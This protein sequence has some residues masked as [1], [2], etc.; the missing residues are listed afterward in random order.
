MN[1]NRKIKENEKIV[2]D[3][4]N[5]VTGNDE[6]KQREKQEPKKKTDDIYVSPSMCDPLGSYTGIPENKYDVPIQDADDL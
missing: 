6:H 2:R 1:K 4:I 5:G 3:V